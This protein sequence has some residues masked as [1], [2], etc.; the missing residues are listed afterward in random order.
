MQPPAASLSPEGEGGPEAVAAVD[1]RGVWTYGQL[2][3]S[4]G[5]F[6]PYKTSLLI[7]PTIRYRA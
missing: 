4:A 3:G 7:N 2:D 1:R 6:V 5:V